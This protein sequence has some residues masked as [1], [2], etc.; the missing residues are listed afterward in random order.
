M[1]LTI[2]G[3]RGSYP[4]CRPDVSRYGGNS[5]CFSIECQG[6]ELIIDGG[7]GIVPL[8]R[9]LTRQYPQGR[10]LSLFLTHSHWDHVLGYPFFGPFYDRRFHI[11]IYGADS[12]NRTL[13]DVF[14]QQYSEDN[15]PVPFQDQGSHLR[16]HRIG[17]GSRINLGSLAVHAIQLNHPGMDLGYRF[18]TGQGDVAILTDLAPI[19]DNL[20]G[21]EMKSHAGDRPRSFELDYSHSLVELIR[22]TDLVIYDT[23]FTEEEI[24]GKRHWGHST[25]EEALRT[26]S[27]LDAPPALVLSHHDPGHDDDTM[28]AIL[29][30]TR[31][32]GK[33]MGIEVLIAREGGVFE[34]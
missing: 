15:F 21:Q 32:L 3:T 10:Q 8:G 5:T 31:R 17:H 11:D 28:D 27:H 33:T 7:T 9:Q 18:S 16:L 34:L 30:H 24:V 22:G 14:S 20:L 2:W 19:K 26:L 25:P 1:R 12:E 23:N 4:V 13:D 29:A 6:Q